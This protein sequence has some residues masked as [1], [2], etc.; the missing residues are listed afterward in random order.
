MIS[1]IHLQPRQKTV[2]RKAIAFSWNPKEEQQQSETGND[3][4]VKVE[5]R[6]MQEV[7]ESHDDQNQTKGDKRIARPQTQDDQ[8]SGNKFDKRDG[9]ANQPKRPD[10]QK[11]ICERQEIFSD[12]FD[13]TKLK[14]FPHAGHAE[15]Q[16]KNQS[17]EE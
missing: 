6:F 1:W 7:A 11:C 16:A 15:N 10:G 9:N 5:E 12:V 3:M 14:H 13:R 8:S 17:R 2:E 4:A